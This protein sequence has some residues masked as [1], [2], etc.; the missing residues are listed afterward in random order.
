MVLAHKTK[1]V[2][3]LKKQKKR[4]SQLKQKSTVSSIKQSM[5]SITSGQIHQCY[6]AEPNDQCPFYHIIISRINETT[7]TII[8]VTFMINSYLTGVEDVYQMEDSIPSFYHLIDYNINE[9]ILHLKQINPAIGK[10]F[11]LLA[12]THAKSCGYDPHPDYHSLKDVFFD[13]DETNT[14]NSTFEFGA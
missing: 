11:I 12:I 10:K 1:Q 3:I 8:S 4:I 9:G 14:P 6:I 5:A 13:I 7:N 2:K